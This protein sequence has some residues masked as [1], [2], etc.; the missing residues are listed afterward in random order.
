MKKLLTEW[1]QFEQQTLLI[2][3]FEQA[4]KEGKVGEWISSN[5]NKLK[6]AVKAFKEK[7]ASGIEPF[8]VAVRKWKAGETLSEEEKTNF[9]KALAT[10]G[11]MMLPGGTTLMILKH[12]VT[13]QMGNIT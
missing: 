13:N 5:L 1:R 12:L 4:L 3:G 10:T 2:E 9:I 8:V 11:I 7:L 6:P